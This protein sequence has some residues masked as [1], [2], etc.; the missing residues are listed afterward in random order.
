MKP[1]MLVPAVFLLCA[2]V[3]PLQ[4]ADARIDSSGFKS[5]FKRTS[6]GVKLHYFEAGKGPALLFLPGWTGA[7]EF[8]APQMRL[9][10]SKWRVVSL[11]PRSQ[12]DSEKVQ[13]GNYTERRARDVHEVIEAL[14]LGPVVL[15]AWSRGVV[16]S[17][18]LVEQFGAA[19]LRALVLVDGTLVRTPN[20][21]AIRQFQQQAKA[22]LR[23][24]KKFVSEQVPSMFR[25]PHGK[26]LYHRIG[27]ANLKTP[28]PTAIALQ[29]DSLDR[30]SRPA[31]KRLDKPVLFINRSGPGADALAAILQ[32]ELPAGRLEIMDNVGHAVFL[33]DPERFNEI[34]S[35]FLET[36]A[37]PSVRGR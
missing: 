12:G 33:D 11:D 15:I 32:K 6:D 27:E 17:L 18:S 25:R 21:A 37:D 31:L 8:W 26:D 13:E 36:V 14:G 1:K 20:D 35:G 3:L 2:S 5:G 28:T 29:V 34:L 19:S 7:A 22:M 24:R 9:L 10:S 4:A 23:D 30:D 16:E